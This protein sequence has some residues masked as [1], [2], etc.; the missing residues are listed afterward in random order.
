MIGSLIDWKY[1]RWAVSD[2]E[3]VKES[4]AEGLG[5]VGVLLPLSS[6]MI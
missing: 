1:K 5:D 3:T 4:E 2:V 6:Y